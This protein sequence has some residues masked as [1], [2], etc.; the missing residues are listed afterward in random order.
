MGCSLYSED[1]RFTFRSPYALLPAIWREN[2]ILL[3]VQ[4]IN[5]GGGKTALPA[6]ASC[7]DELDTFWMVKPELD[8]ESEKSHEQLISLCGDRISKAAYL[9]QRGQVCHQWCVLFADQIRHIL[10]STSK[11]TYL[12]LLSLT[13]S[14]PHFPQMGSH[15]RL[16]FLVYG[17]QY[18]LLSA[19]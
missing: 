16:T 12:I 13:P 4:G 1:H 6:G 9:V 3:E 5:C 10:P 2:T 11:T 18:Y 8:S 7:L 15:Q 19:K 14:S 17:L